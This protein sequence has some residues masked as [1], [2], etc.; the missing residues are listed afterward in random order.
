MLL[1]DTGGEGGLRKEGRHVKVIVSLDEDRKWA[2]VKPCLE[3]KPNSFLPRR[4]LALVFQ[5]F[6]QMFRPGGGLIISWGL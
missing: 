2:E 4:C 5:C 6:S 1:E 3:K